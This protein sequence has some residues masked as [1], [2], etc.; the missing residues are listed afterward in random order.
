MTKNEIYKAISDYHWMIKVLINSRLEYKSISQSFVAK[1]GIESVMPNGKGS[2]SDPIYQEM[3]RL[4]KYENKNK[5]IIEKVEFVQQHMKYIKHE[6]DNII[7]NSI[8]CGT[9]MR[10]IAEE[11]DTSIGA[12]QKRKE[13]I[14]KIMYQSQNDKKSQ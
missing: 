5:N 9:P 4:E 14:A 3:L 6:R 8:L 1:T 12:V 2:H 11:L 7:L 13:V 10:E